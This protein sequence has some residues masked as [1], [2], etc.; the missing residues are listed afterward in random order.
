M[1]DDKDKSNLYA[2]IAVQDNFIDYYAGFGWKKSGQFESK[3]A[4]ENY[5]NDFALK[6]NNP[7]KITFN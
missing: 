5:L 6:V 7:L 2:H 1:V 4:W 3:A